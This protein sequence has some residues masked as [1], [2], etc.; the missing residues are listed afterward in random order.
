MFVCGLQEAAERA[1]QVQLST[2]HATCSMQA[3][4][5]RQEQSNL[6]AVE[7]QLREASERLV[8]AERDGN[9]LE[10]TTVQCVLYIID[11]DIKGRA[12]YIKDL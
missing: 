10:D 2:V 9:A 8:S 11:L 5:L 7:K 6:Q 12:F 3:S 1:L 4:Q